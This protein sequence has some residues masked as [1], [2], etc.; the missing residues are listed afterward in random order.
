MKT[1]QMLLIALGIAFYSAY[2]AEDIVLRTSAEPTEAWIGQRVILR[3]D[4][5]GKD[6]WAQ[7]PKIGSLDIPGAYVMRTDSQGS[8]LQER[9]DGDSYT[10]QRYELSLYPQRTGAIEIPELPV[11]VTKR[12][13]GINASEEIFE[14][15]APAITIHSKVPPGGEGIR[16]LIS[17]T[18]LAASQ[19]WDPVSI[20]EPMTV[21][22]AITRTI[23]R[24]ADDVSGMAFAP[25]SFPEST[26]LGIYPSEPEVE[27]S[28]DRGSL[29]GRREQ[30]VTY[31]F[32]NPGTVEIPV[33]EL[34]WWDVDAEELKTIELTGR[35]IQVLGLA[36]SASVTTAGTG[37]QTSLRIGWIAAVLL[38]VLVLSGARYRSRL[39]EY[40]R[41]ISRASKNSEAQRFRRALT[42]IRSGDAKIALRMIT[43]WLDHSFDDGRPARLDSFLKRYGDSET[44]EEIFR[45]VHSL[46]SS[47]SAWDAQVVLAGLKA[48]RTRWRKVR[49]KNS[50]FDRELPHLNVR[51][52]GSQSIGQ[53]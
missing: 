1:V 44:Q 38:I 31:V 30:S 21:G 16:G 25:L 46:C 49:T 22:D 12:E 26:G 20:P 32:E 50:N 6:G 15:T 23:T 17:T 7:I 51:I 42:A 36:S 19:T 45:L 27:D 24:Q 43:E 18:Q 3:I 53:R 14:I 41:R 5:L 13:L 40:W 4:V 33:I 2:A 47:A 10:G 34:T 39:R 48:A 11:K 35:T 29:S 52:T 8:R 9:I 37:D 28:A